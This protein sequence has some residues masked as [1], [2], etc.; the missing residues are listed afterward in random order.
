M[1]FLS[2]V[3]VLVWFLIPTLVI[4]VVGVFAISKMSSTTK[5]E[6]KPE[7]VSSPVE[8]TVDFSIVSQVHIAEGTNGSEFNSNPPSSGPH[9]PSPAAKGIYDTPLPDERT[10]HNMEHG[11]VWIAYIPAKSGSDATA[12]AQKE[13]LSEEDVNKLKDIVKADDYKLIMTPRAA[14]DTKIAMV[15]WG[16]VLKLDNLDEQKV[17]DFIRTYRNRGPEKTMEE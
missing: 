3:P 12:E 10:I 4:V 7:K 6:S 16:R 17:K 8:G 5:D 2:R 15:A 14:N 11:Y 9:W 1:R 13:G